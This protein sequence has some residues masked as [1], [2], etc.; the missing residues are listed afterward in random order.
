M[1]WID[2]II[3]GLLEK[4]NTNNI[5]EICRG[6]NIKI[7]KLNPDNIL[8]SKKEACYYRD[9][10]DNE[11]IFIRNNLPLEKEQFI[12]KHELGHALLHP[13]VL[14]AAYSFYSTGKLERQ[15]NYFALKLSNIC[16]D[17]IELENLTLEQIAA[18]VGVP[19]EPLRQVL[20]M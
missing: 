1:E 4:Y 6:E 15:A 7:V 16:L 12:L 2:D 9:L 17:K 19:Y 8:L 13:D 5:Y 18:Y 20:E 10:D 14:S 11:V 3:L